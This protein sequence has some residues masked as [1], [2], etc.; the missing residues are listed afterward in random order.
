MF[1]IQL[2]FI[3]NAEGFSEVLLLK[4]KSVCEFEGT[5]KDK[6]A[7]CLSRSEVEA[8]CAVLVL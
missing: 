7:V 4:D 6:V 8:H 1:I 5:Q 3:N 2:I